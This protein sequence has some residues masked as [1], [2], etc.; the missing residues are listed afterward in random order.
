MQ[1]D[2]KKAIAIWERRCAELTESGT[3]K[4]DMPPKSIHFRK[5]VLDPMVGV[6]EEDENESDSDVE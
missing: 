1:A 5:P 3:K 2:H 4:K 6:D